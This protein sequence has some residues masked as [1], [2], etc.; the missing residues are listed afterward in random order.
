MFEQ[1]AGAK[2][3]HFCSSAFDDTEE[4]EPMTKKV[5]FAPTEKT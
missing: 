2:L 3:H 4:H 5:S 1:K